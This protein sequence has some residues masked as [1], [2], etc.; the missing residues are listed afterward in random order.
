MT[1]RPILFSGEMVRAI[2]DGRKTQTRRVIRPQPKS[3]INGW[4]TTP[5]RR[6]KPFRVR[7]PFVTSGAGGTG[8]GSRAEDVYPSK[9]KTCSYGIVGDRLYVREQWQR[10]PTCGILNYGA[11]TKLHACWECDNELG[12]W[13]PSIHMFKEYSRIKLLVTDVRVELV[14]DIT[15]EDCKAE[16]VQLTISDLNTVHAYDKPKTLIWRFSQLWNSINYKRGFGWDVNPWVWAITF[17]VITD[18]R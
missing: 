2:L 12:G 10:C 6:Q 17:E 7:V 13:K 15:A 9:M 5:D 8:F 14:Q 1:E 11:S 18:E 16:G 4:P 3:L